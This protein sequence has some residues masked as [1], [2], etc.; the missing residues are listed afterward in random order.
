MILPQL[1]ARDRHTYTFVC[2]HTPEQANNAPGS[3]TIKESGTVKHGSYD[4]LKPMCEAIM[5]GCI[6][7]RILSWNIHPKLIEMPG[8]RSFKNFRA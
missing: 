1:L 8:Q 2:K 6:D 5:R 4:E 7:A 3:F